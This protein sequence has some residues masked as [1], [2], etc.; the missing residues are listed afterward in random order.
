MNGIMWPPTGKNSS[1]NMQMTSTGKEI[2]GGKKTRSN[3]HN[4]GWILSFPWS[5]SFYISSAPPIPSSS[6]FKHYLL[7][8]HSST[9]FM[10]AQPPYSPTPTHPLLFTLT[11]ILG[12]VLCCNKFLLFAG[13]GKETAKDLAKRGARVIL[14]CRNLSK[15]QTVAGE[16][17]LSLYSSSVFSYLS[18]FH[19]RHHI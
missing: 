18:E 3:L 13:I 19:I 11:R 4:F 12:L 16:A 1:G 15:A 17:R 8:P 6:I 7:H 9:N 5:L 2:E 14:A 10:P